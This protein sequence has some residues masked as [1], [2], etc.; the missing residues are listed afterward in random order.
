M[1]DER[2]KRMSTGRP[3]TRA[4]DLPPEWLHHLRTIKA[5]DEA[6]LVADEKRA[7]FRNEKGDEGLTFRQIQNLDEYQA[8]STEAQELR[9]RRIDAMINAIN[10]GVSM[11]RIAKHIG[12]SSSAHVSLLVKGRERALAKE[13][14]QEG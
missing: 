6:W 8:L 3:P 7:A 10:D 4:K 11:Y 5:A 13:R 2:T 14:A 12:L 1:S 9:T